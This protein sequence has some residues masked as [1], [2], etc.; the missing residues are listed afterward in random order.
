MGP[1]LEAQTE[2]PGPFF[3]L[4]VFPVLT[5]SSIIPC[6]VREHRKWAKKILDAV[7]KQPGIWDVDSLG[8]SRVWKKLLQ[9]RLFILNSRCY[10]WPLYSPGPTAECTV[11]RSPAPVLPRCF[12]YSPS[13]TESNVRYVECWLKKKKNRW[14]E[15]LHQLTVSLKRRNY[16]VIEAGMAP[17]FRGW[18][19]SHGGEGS[20]SWRVLSE[21]EARKLQWRPTPFFLTH[22][23]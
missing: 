11:R 2:K 16:P 21:S 23:A 4:A 15:D 17:T 13:E 22:R 20:R 10:P 6:L 7:L 18:S 19:G 8:T 9:F 12:V 3:S 1:K 5:V 14:R